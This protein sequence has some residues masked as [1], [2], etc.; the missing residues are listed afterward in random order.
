MFTENETP[1]RDGGFG[2]RP[3]S[4]IVLATFFGVGCQDFGNVFVGMS[5]VRV[6]PPP[7]PRNLPPPPAAL[8]SLLPTPLP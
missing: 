4:Q 7:L 1:H 8:H 5:N 3:K 6:S 2:F